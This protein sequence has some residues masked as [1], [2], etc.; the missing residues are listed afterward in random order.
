MDDGG[1]TMGVGCRHEGGLIGGVSFSDTPSPWGG[2]G[3]GGGERDASLVTLTCS[4]LSLTLPHEGGGDSC[5]V[6]AAVT[7][8]Y[9][10]SSIADQQSLTSSTNTPSPSTGEGWGEGEQRTVVLADVGSTPTLALVELLAARLSPQA[11]KSTVIPP[12]G[13]GNHLW[14]PR[15]RGDAAVRAPQTFDRGEG[16]A[17]TNT[18]S[19]STGEGWGEGDQRTVASADDGSTPTLALPP[20]GGGDSL[21]VGVGVR[22][23]YQKPFIA[24][25][26]T[27]IPSANTPSPL[28][29]EGWGGGEQPPIDQAAFLAFLWMSDNQHQKNSSP[30]AA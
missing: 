19:P 14:E 6:S 15:P 28:R 17:P 10:K 5:L 21:V 20:Q 8:T 22:Q 2:E 30:C 1:L 13:G 24:D 27:L 3:W 25:Q 12:Q 4:P 9:E 18:P 16:A 7:Q 29:G 23:S 11:G 26:Q